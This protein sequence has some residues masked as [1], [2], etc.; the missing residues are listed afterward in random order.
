MACITSVLIQKCELPFPI[1]VTS[2]MKDLFGKNGTL[3]VKLQTNKKP[4]IYNLFKKKAKSIT[5]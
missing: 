2:F 3:S 5:V 4:G 1:G